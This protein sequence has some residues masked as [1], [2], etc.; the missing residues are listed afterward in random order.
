MSFFEKTPY[1]SSYS[2]KKDSISEQD[3]PRRLKV[4]LKHI[5]TNACKC[6]TDE[7]TNV[8]STDDHNGSSTSNQKSVA[9][10]INHTTDGSEHQVR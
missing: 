4:A 8:T 2:D 1:S 5:Q 6:H 9:D 3:S 10:N 7:K